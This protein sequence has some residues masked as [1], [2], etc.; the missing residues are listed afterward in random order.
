MPQ[1]NT[2]RAA[3]RSP[4]DHDPVELRRRRIEAGRTLIDV[5]A[6]AD[7]SAGHLSELESGTRNPSPPLLLRLAETLG[8]TTTDLMP[9]RVA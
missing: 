7:I 9:R 6:A 5:A 4:L 1:T 8:C 3:A 2:R